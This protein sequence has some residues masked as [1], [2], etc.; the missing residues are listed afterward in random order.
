MIAPVMTV[1]IGS[2]LV[3]Q[4][5]APTELV[6]TWCKHEEVGQVDARYL[7]RANDFPPDECN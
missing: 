3:C 1:W 4:M 5:G 6:L 7:A 2:G